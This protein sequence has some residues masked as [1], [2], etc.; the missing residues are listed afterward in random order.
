MPE[1]EQQTEQQLGTETGFGDFSQLLEENFKPTTETKSEIESAI[2]TLAGQALQNTNLIKE[3]SFETIERLISAIDE[4]MSK[5]MSLVLHNEEFQE[6][7]SKWRGL[8]HLVNNTETSTKL[9]IRFMNISKKEMYKTLMRFKGTKW[10]QSPMFKAIYESEFGVAGGSPYSCLIGDY[11]FDHSPPDVNFLSEMSH[12]SAAAH[13]PFIS[14]V[15]PSIVNMESWQEISN[16]RDIAQ[17]FDA[18]QYATWHSFRDSPDS[19]YVS[20]TMPRFLGRL[21]YGEKT[22]PTDEF[23][24]EED[25]DGTDHNSYS[26]VNASYALATNIHRSFSLYGWASQIAGLESG[27]IVDDLPVH[28][29]N[30]SDGGIDAKCPTEVSITDRRENE[31]ATAGISSLVHYKGTDYGVFFK[32]SSLRKPVQY[33]DPEATSNAK[34]A[35]NMSY[36]LATSRFAHYLKHIVRNKLGSSVTKDRLQTDLQRW[37]NSYVEPSPNTASER[38]LAERPLSAAEVTIEEDEETPGYYKARFY[39]KPHY[40]LEGMT[41]GL[42]LVS[43]L[44][45]E[46]E[47]K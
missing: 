43:R 34:L 12:I 32:A 25:V 20:L 27:G 10:D 5:Q 6:L 24:F 31:F 17:V 29:F 28:T 39:L 42:S 35:T 47:G 40:K 3:D 14:A 2:H 19:Q 15:S 4:K 46:R 41:I 11:Y 7:E 38:G 36:M 23:G 26:W 22:N 13:A 44:P 9:K 18:P 16:P 1:T 37:I 30:T 8:H 45:S 33:D 21:P